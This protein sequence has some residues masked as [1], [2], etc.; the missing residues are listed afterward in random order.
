MELRKLISMMP[1]YKIVRFYA[2]PDQE[3]EFVI[4]NLTLEEA[5]DHCDDPQT[6]SR[7]CT[8]EDATE[9]T[10]ACGPWFDGY[11]EEI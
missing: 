7:T 11:T 1:K 4:G 5:H 2:D 3:R 10:Q 8:D 6:S 9:R